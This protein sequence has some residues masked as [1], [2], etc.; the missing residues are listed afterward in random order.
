MPFDTLLTGGRIV[1]GSGNPWFRGDVA[2]AGDRVV[3]IAAPG[4]IP[5]EQVRAVVD[6]AAARTKSVSARPR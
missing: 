2:L 6:V 1:D 4:A 3:A 5:T